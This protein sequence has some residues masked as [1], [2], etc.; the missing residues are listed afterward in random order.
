MLPAICG[1][2]IKG[3][4]LGC[5]KCGKKMEKFRAFTP[6]ESLNISEVESV[7]RKKLHS[8]EIG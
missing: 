4:V 1:K 7:F 3:S 6:I 5:V 2:E 8:G